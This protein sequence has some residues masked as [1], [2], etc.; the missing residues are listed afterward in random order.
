M[1]QSALAPGAAARQAE[2]RKRQRY[3]DLSQRYIFEPVTRETS[4]VH[5]SAAAAFVQD[6][7]RRISVKTG[8][9]RETAWLMQRLSIA[10]ARGNAAS[11]LATA[12]HAAA[13]DVYSA[14][15]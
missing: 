14:S 7:G 5:G 4:G 8:E 13:E 6:L 12:P 2:E 10:I 9:K 15:R 11:V 3:V 1:V